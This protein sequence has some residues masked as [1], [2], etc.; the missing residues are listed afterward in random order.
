MGII[1]LI[2]G[3]IGVFVFTITLSSILRGFVLS[4]LWGW[5]IVPLFGLPSLSISFA[6]GLCLVVGM[7][8]SHPS[9][10]DHEIETSTALLQGFVSPFIVL[11][12]GWIV[13][14]FLPAIG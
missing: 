13:T 12:I 3:G 1:M 8:Q 9:Y 4:K 14:M 5:F 2:F 11:F 6:I 7:F 10:K